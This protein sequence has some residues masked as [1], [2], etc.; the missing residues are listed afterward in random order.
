MIRKRLANE[1]AKYSSVLPDLSISQSE[2]REIEQST[3]NTL[4][5]RLSVHKVRSDNTL[6]ISLSPIIKSSES[7]ILSLT[8][9]SVHFEDY[10]KPKEEV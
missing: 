1:T 7:P 4:L 3:V 5:S 6:N 10:A 9:K 2:L 8:K